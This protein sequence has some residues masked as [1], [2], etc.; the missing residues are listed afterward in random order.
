LRS[1]C[2]VCSATVSA[3]IW[4]ST[5]NATCPATWSTLPLRTPWENAATGVGAC[6]VLISTLATGHPFVTSPAA[7]GR[8]GGRGRLHP[9]HEGDQP[10]V[11]EENLRH[12]HRDRRDHLAALPP[13]GRGDAVDEVLVLGV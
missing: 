2:R 10:V 4:P 3:T 11:V 13:D 12:G 7:L 9:R 5:S 8:G 6:D 1:A